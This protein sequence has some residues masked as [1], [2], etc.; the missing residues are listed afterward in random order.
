MPADAPPP[1][2][3]PPPHPSEIYIFWEIVILEEGCLWNIISMHGEY[4]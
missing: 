3:P 4:Q 2:P 1:P